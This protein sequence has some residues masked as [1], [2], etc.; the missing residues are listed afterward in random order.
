MYIVCL[1]G[2]FAVACKT[3]YA[4]LSRKGVRVYLLRAVLTYPYKQCNFIF[5]YST[6]CF[7]LCI[8]VVVSYSRKGVYLHVKLVTYVQWI[9]PRLVPFFA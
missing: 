8:P 3:L 1:R 5:E 9:T 7:S 6:E 4:W 2:Y